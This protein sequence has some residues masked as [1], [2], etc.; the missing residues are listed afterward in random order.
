[1]YQTLKTQLISP[2]RS[3]FDIITL[4]EAFDKD[5]NFMVDLILERSRITKEI[6]WALLGEDQKN[7]LVSLISKRPRPIY[8]DFNNNLSISAGKKRAS[9][10]VNNI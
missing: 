4:K 6:I 7:M 8:V 5:L 3:N 1:V 9:N 2:E 10:E